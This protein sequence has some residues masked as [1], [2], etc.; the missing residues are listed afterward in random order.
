MAYVVTENCIRCMFM[1]CV[2]VCPVSCFYVG[3]NMLV[4]HPGQ[5]VDCGACEPIC[6]SKAIVPD[7]DSR[8]DAWRETNIRYSEVW[9][10][11]SR[12]ASKPRP[13]AEDW[14]DV[15]DK[16]K[17]FSPEPGDPDAFPG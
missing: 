14:K 17:F 13:E 15:P 6:P 11:I 4:I 3:A 5:C 9:P 7:S 10:N 16:G 12:R 8:A 1:V 2:E